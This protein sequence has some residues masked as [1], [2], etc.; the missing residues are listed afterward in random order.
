MLRVKGP[1]RLGRRD[2]TGIV[3]S[4]L[5]S[6][7]LPAVAATCGGSEVSVPVVF[8]FANPEYQVDWVHRSPGATS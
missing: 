8:S 2:A 5:L 3:L 1:C 4:A 7:S 6:G